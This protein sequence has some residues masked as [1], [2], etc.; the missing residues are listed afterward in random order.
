MIEGRYIPCTISY[1]GVMYR[2]GDVFTSE[3]IYGDYYY[4]CVL[5]KD[6]GGYRQ[7]TLFE[8]VWFDMSELKL[9][10][11]MDSGDFIMTKQLTTVD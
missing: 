2:F 6:V 11:S 9:Y 7:G 8:S 5:L 10:F 4:K 1:L 3:I